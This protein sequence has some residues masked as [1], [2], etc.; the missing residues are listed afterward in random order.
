[1]V[2]TVTEVDKVDTEIKAMATKEVM[3]TEEATEE[4]VPVVAMEVEM[5]AVTK[6][7]VE[8]TEEE[9]E[10]EIDPNTLIK[11]LKQFSWAVSI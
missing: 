5:V 10:E 8:E 1:M 4:P 6:A 7:T 9:M 2:E 11:T 3:V